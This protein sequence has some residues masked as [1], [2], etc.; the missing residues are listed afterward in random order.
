MTHRRLRGEGIGARVL[1]SGQSHWLGRSARASASR[2]DGSAA[3][4]AVRRATQE[5]TYF[6]GWHKNQESLQPTPALAGPFGN[7]GIKTSK[8]LGF[9]GV[10]LPLPL[11]ANQ[12]IGPRI[13][14]LC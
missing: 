8:T 14:P 3:P 1:P 10:L 9:L 11:A 12:K 13:T 4:G 7:R 2:G 5:R 6:F